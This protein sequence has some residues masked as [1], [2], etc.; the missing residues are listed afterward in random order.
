MK[1]YIGQSSGIGLGVFAARDIAK[2]EVIEVCHVLAVPPAEVQHWDSTLLGDYYY[3][4]GP[5][6]TGAALALGHGSL[7][8][9]SF[10]PNAWYSKDIERG[11][12]R[13]IPLRDIAKGEEVRINYNAD[14]E[15]QT[16]VRFDAI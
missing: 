2:S 4:W 6:L 12:I 14:P 8:N 1:T 11:V 15:D 3:A 9:H 7:Y 16:L 13:I 10:A 5:E